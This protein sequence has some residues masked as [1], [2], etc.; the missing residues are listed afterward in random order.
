MQITEP[1]DVPAELLQQY[2]AA[3]SLGKLLGVKLYVTKRGGFRRLGVMG[4]KKTD[5]GYK[6]FKSRVTWLQILTRKVFRQACDC[7]KLQPQTGGAVP[8]APGPRGRDWWYDQAAGSGL[9]YYDYFMQQTIN[10]INAGGT[11]QWCYTENVLA[12][13][14]A[15]S[16][17]TASCETP[18]YAAATGSNGTINNY[19]LIVRPQTNV[20]LY[21]YSYILRWS[22]GVIRPLKITFDWVDNEWPGGYPTYNNFPHTGTRF[23][24]FIV[25]PHADY[26][27]RWYVV[28]CRKGKNII[29]HAE[30][31]GQ[32]GEAILLAQ[33]LTGN[34][35]LVPKCQAFW[36]VDRGAY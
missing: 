14:I 24:E 28:D 30:T 21:I 22:D 17:P 27:G 31:M 1:Q 23:K 18:V 11:P 4:L 20:T 36:K 33:F 5:Y 8:P 35:W 19:A 29:I 32:G 6:G 25:L 3:L 7:W 15:Q 34:Y 16:M 12:R 13:W 10:A 2:K 9:W 26:K